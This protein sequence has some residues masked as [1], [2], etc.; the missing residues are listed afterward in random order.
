MFIE[1]QRNSKTKDPR[2]KE[3][4][5]RLISLAKQNNLSLV[6][7]SDCHYIYPED[8]EAQ[9]VLVCI[10]T[11]RTV[12]EADR[13]DM[14]GNDLSLHSPEK[15]R[16]LFYDIP[17][18]VENTQKVADMCNLE[19]LIDQRYFPK[20]KIPEGVTSEE[21]LRRITY[22]RAIPLYGKPTDPK[23]PLSAMVESVNMADNNLGAD[24]KK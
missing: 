7:T 19:I 16:E 6:A 3:L 23:M 2:E 4:N 24:K 1:L 18:A 12:G 5:Q 14:R 22:E 11:G 15:M 9:D 13:L 8:S 20:V 17:E 10:G 21:F